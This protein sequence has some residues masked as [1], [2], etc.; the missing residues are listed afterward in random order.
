MI[1]NKTTGQTNHMRDDGINYLQDVL[2][3][4]PEDIERVAAELAAVAACQNWN[5]GNAEDSSFGWQGR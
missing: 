5:S 1:I 3:V 4:P 2:I